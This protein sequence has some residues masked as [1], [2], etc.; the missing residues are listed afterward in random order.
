MNNFGIYRIYFHKIRMHLHLCDFLKHSGERIKGFCEICVYLDE[1]FV[2]LEDRGESVIEMS[3]ASLGVFEF[4]TELLVLMTERAPDEV[5]GSITGVF[6][7][8]IRD[9]DSAVEA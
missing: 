8:S 1:C 4:L 7:V 3:L 6:E 5:D 2:V 9:V